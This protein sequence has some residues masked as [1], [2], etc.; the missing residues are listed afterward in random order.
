MSIIAEFTVPAE[1]FALYETLCEVPGMTVEIERVV[2]HEEEWMVPYF[3]TSGENYTRFEEKAANDPSIRELTKLDE[4]EGANLYRSEWVRD[5]ETVAYTMTETG[6]TLLDA[7]GRDGRWSMEL[8]FDT[9]DGTAAFQD[10]L[11]ENELG[12]SY[13]A[14][15][16]RPDPGWTDSRD[17]PMPSTRRW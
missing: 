6:A 3:W 4:V 17:S 16:S 7:T 2:A 12:R 5:V 10:Y 11:T 13:T 14:S 15:T 1:E 8:R 9:R